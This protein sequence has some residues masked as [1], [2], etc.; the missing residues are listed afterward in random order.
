MPRC[1]D[2]VCG[3]WKPGLPTSLWTSGVRFNGQWYCSR[4]CVE[5]AARTGLDTPAVPAAPASSLPPLKLGA[6]LRHLG[7]LSEAD[8]TSALDTQR[9]SGLRLGAELRRRNLVA[10]E[11][12]LRALA[13]QGGISYFASFDVARVT[14]GPAWLPVETVRALGLVPFDVDEPQRTL[15]VVCAAPVP[16]TATRALVKLTGW[17]AEPYLVDDEVLQDA[18]R[19]YRPAHVTEQV[20]EAITVA[21]VAAAA[22][23]VADTVAAGRALTMRTANCDRYTWVR[24]EG[25]AH[26]S[27]LLVNRP[28]ERVHARRRV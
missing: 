11:A 12:I 15:R 10:P 28:Q 23:R 19:A 26:V 22:A 4:G 3:R 9:E 16:R 8:L 25:P 2:P 24:L 27:D 17:T 21:N 20:G 1:A 5:H 13:A 18:M 7:V 6:L 14:R